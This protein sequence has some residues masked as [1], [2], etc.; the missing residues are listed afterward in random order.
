CN[1][2]KSFLSETC[3]Q[4]RFTRARFTNKRNGA[5]FCHHGAGMQHELSSPAE[6]KRKHLIKKEMSQGFE[7]DFSNGITLNALSGA[8]DVKICQVWEAQQVT[9]FLFAKEEPNLLFR[10]TPLVKPPHRNR[11]LPPR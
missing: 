10:E 4:S 1:E 8:G 7:G 3:S 6:G 11:F 9:I 5:R 2:R